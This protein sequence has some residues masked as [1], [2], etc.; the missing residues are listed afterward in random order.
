MPAESVNRKYEWARREPFGAEEKT[1]ILNQL[2]GL[3]T[4]PSDRRLDFVFQDHS[5]RGIRQNEQHDV[6]RPVNG[7]PKVKVI[8]DAFDRLRTCGGGFQ[9]TD[10][11]NIVYKMFGETNAFDAEAF[12]IKYPP[13]L[14][15]VTSKGLPC[16]QV[17]GGTAPWSRLV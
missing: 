4:L 12:A 6:F 17:H 9:V 3:Y 15:K 10:M 5:L 11:G 2:G 16:I 13:T 8:R 14:W 7:R 1:E